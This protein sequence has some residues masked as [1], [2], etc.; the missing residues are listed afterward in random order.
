MG[1]F[2]TED[3]PLENIKNRTY[4]EIAQ[5]E[6]Q[7]LRQWLGRQPWFGETDREIARGATRAMERVRG[8]VLEDGLGEILLLCQEDSIESIRGEIVRYLKEVERPNITV[9]Q[10]K[11]AYR[12]GLPELSEILDTV[13]EA[14]FSP[15]DDVYFY[16]TK[17]FHA[18][19]IDATRGGNDGARRIVDLVKSQPW[20]L[21]TQAID[22]LVDTEHPLA[23]ELVEEW[24][25]S[26]T[27][28][29]EFTSDSEPVRVS[30]KVARA[31]KRRFQ[32]APPLGKEITSTDLQRMR[33]WADDQPWS[34][35]KSQR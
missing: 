14:G 31:L 3:V 17:Y 21:Q 15:R 7:T 18:C 13:M 24:L 33:D 30:H 27:F 11:L 10:M 9:V 29:G 20:R 2:S 8:N 1:K 34:K 35:G 32:G 19:Q 28:V 12:V 5:E 16:E 26:E 4:S 6:V 25:L 23:L 22:G